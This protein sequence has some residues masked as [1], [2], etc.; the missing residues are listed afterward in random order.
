MREAIPSFQSALVAKLST[1]MV[2]LAALFTAGAQADI[3]DPRPA[4]GV[5]GM[6]PTSRELAQVLIRQDGGKVYISEN[7]TGYRDFSTSFIWAPNRWPCQ[8]GA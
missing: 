2:G 6:R 3:A 4:H 5:D 8:S 1:A 7:G